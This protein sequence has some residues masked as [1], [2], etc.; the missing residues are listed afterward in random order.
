[1]VEQD[2]PERHI[3]D[4]YVETVGYQHARSLLWN[5][6]Y[7]RTEADAERPRSI[8]TVAWL[9]RPPHPVRPELTSIGYPGRRLRLV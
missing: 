3:I 8:R 5:H 2:M 6:F 4:E 9:Q 7:V 1:L